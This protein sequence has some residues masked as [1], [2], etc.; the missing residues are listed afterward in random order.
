MVDELVFP[1]LWL[2]FVIAEIRKPKN[3]FVL[4]CHKPLKIIDGKNSWRNASVYLPWVSVV[5]LR[6]KTKY[7][8]LFFVKLHVCVMTNTLIECPKRHWLPSVSNGQVGLLKSCAS[9]LWETLDNIMCIAGFVTVEKVSPKLVAHHCLH[10]S[11][12][13][14]PIS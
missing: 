9:H 10:R 3:I 7:R 11:A 4:D 1:E 13:Q 14:S 12:F 5:V 2:D 8:I 6:L